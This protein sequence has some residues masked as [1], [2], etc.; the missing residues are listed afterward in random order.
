MISESPRTVAK[1]LGFREFERVRYNEE[2]IYS[3]SKDDSQEF[4]MVTVTNEGNKIPL[5]EF[6]LFNPEATEVL[7]EGRHGY[8][9]F[10]FFKNREA[11]PERTI[12]ELD[13]KIHEL[14]RKLYEV[15]MEESGGICR[16]CK[17]NKPLDSDGF[18]F[19]C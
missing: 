14:E 2:T 3:Y 8:E 18:C 15:E 16:S 9:L 19:H 1:E 4:L 7:K 10:Y 5:Y 13:E 17:R 6:T 11:K 12:E